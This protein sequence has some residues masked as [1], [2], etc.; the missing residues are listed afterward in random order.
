MVEKAVS[1]ITVFEHESL[2][3]D[4]GEQ[5]LTTKQ[6]AALQA[7]YGNKG[8]PYYSLV[9]KG[10]RF[11]EHAGIIQV[12]RTVIEILPKADKSGDA[13]V[14]RN[15]LVSMLQAVGVFDV[16]SPGSSHLNLKAHSVLDL[17][18]ALFVQEM[19]YLIRRG[20]IKKYRRTEGNQTALKGSIQFARHISQNIVHQERFYVRC[21]TYDKQ[22]ELHALL[23][24]TLQLLVRLNVPASL[25][26]R[27]TVLL[28]DFPEVYSP[29]ILKVTEDT[30]RKIHFDRKTA[31]YRNAIKIARLLLLNYHPDISRG[32]HDVLAIM[33]NMNLLWEQ[34]VYGSLKKYSPQGSSVEAQTVKNFWQPV[35]GGYPSRM[36]PDIILNAHTPDCMVLDTKWKNIA[37]QRNPSPQDLRQMF[38]Y[39]TYYKAKKTALVYPGSANDSRSGRYYNE[40]G[41]KGELSHKQCSIL[42]I[43]VQQNVM[44][45]QKS[46][47]E[48]LHTMSFV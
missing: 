8:V 29:K 27:L 37:G 36:K 6:L 2:H 40:H 41:H 42:S 10:I 31:P 9:H 4:R 18:F 39:M 47:A 43:G 13:N 46:I 12:G 28:M 22:H 16:Q 45:W 5:R 14:W 21:T 19:E 44:L 48:A 26:S 32:N 11:N 7:F 23:Y 34:F 24:K 15:V 33:F 3:T 35:A 30:F 20:L 17:Y 1:H 25:K 38:V